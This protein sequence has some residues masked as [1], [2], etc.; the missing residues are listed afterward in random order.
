MK[1][2]LLPIILALLC[3]AFAGNN[4]RMY[5][6]LQSVTTPV[7]ADAERL[8]QLEQEKESW[9]SKEYELLRQNGEL[10][11]QL[12]ELKNQQPQTIIKY[13][14]NEKKLNVNRDASQ[15]ITTILSNRYASESN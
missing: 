11:T 13:R 4:Y 3:L 1:K 14:T 12:N 6:K 2:S 7:S 10:V 15:R 9:D 8:K 5:K